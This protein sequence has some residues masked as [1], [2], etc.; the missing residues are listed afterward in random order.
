MEVSTSPHYIHVLPSSAT[1]PQRHTPCRVRFRQVGSL[2]S[3]LTSLILVGSQL[4]N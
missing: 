3:Y 1:E 2:H 4:E